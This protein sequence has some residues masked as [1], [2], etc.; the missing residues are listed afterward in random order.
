MGSRVNGEISDYE[1]QI[2]PS[3]QVHSFAVFTIEFPPELT[4]PHTDVECDSL[5]K[6]LV[7]SIKC[8]IPSGN[9][10]E[11]ILQGVSLQLL[12]GVPFK[13]TVKKVRNAPS[14]KPTSFFQNM[15][16][17]DS[18][19]DYDLTEFHEIITNGKSNMPYVQNDQLG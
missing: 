16:F 17:K 12:A 3:T 6:E 13:I 8:T 1:I 7:A 11:I 9:T 15:M 2:I 10:M 19:L 18:I 4:L 14:T 5:S